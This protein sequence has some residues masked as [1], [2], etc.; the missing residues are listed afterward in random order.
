MKVYLSDVEES[1][2]KVNTTSSSD[3]G[4]FNADSDSMSDDDR[5]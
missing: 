2:R 4:Y 5:D 3:G 1:K